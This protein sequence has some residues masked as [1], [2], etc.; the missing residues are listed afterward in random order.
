[1]GM[2]NRQ[3]P[4]WKVDPKSIDPES[5]Q[6]VMDIERVLI[7]PDTGAIQGDDYS[8]E[9]DADGYPIL[10][11]CLDRRPKPALAKGRMSGPVPRLHNEDP[12][13]GHRA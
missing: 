7:E 9:T 11:A 2:S 10:P 6:A 12:C 4:I 5:I 1:M 13:N 3:T 8:I